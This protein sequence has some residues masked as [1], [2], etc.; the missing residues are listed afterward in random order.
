MVLGT[1][2]RSRTVSLNSEIHK[3]SEG[4]RSRWISHLKACPELERSSTTPPDSKCY[5]SS[6]LGEGRSETL[7]CQPAVPQ[8]L[9]NSPKH[10]ASAKRGR[11]PPLPAQELKARQVA[12]MLQG[13]QVL[14]YIAGF[15]LSIALHCAHALV[16][17]S[18]L[19]CRRSR[20]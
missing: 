19:L 12:Q 3:Y 17:L 20:P 10:K 4:S 11:F 5:P 2:L 7:P 16:A 14:F 6:A 9:S 1:G 15:F 18:R 13:L 8:A